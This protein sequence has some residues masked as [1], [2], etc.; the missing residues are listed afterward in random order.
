MCLTRLPVRAEQPPTV[1]F[2]WVILIATVLRECQFDRDDLIQPS[3]RGSV[4]GYSVSWANLPLQR[5]TM[6]KV[7]RTGA[8]QRERCARDLRPH[9]TH[10]LSFRVRSEG[11]NDTLALDYRPRP[12]IRPGCD[13]SNSTTA[14]AH[15]G[16]WREGLR[17]RCVSALQGC[18]PAG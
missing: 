13:W 1:L 6:P 4:E 16:A 17:T 5:R 7:A 3:P 8:I 18:P 9:P 2:S 10:Y 11:Q 15:A 14:A 12:L